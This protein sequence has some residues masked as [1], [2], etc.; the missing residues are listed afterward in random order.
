MVVLILMVQSL[1][2][3]KCMSDFFALL[4]KGLIGVYS[5]ITHPVSGSLRCVLLKEPSHVAI[6]DFVIM[7]GIDSCERFLHSDRLII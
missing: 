6:V 5:V 7:A 4:H 3:V 1:E 2:Q